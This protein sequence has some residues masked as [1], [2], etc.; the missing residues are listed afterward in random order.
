MKVFRVALCLLLFAPALAGATQTRVDDILQQHA[1]HGIGS[2]A[3][4]TAALEAA[5][6]RPGPGDTVERRSPYWF[7][8]GMYAAHQRNVE[9]TE[10]AVRELRSLANAG[11]EPC[12]TQALLVRGTLAERTRKHTKAQEI[13]EQLQNAPPQDPRT[14]LAY[15]LFRS[16]VLEGSGQFDES[17]AAAV[18]A[19]RMAEEQGMPS[20]QVRAMNLLLLANLGRKD[21]KQA[22]KVSH[23]AL[24]LAKRIG[25]VEQQVFVR[26]NQGFLYSLMEQPK[27][28]LQALLDVVQLT[29]SNPALRQSAMVVQVNLGDFYYLEGDYAKALQHAREGER[30]ARELNDSV[31]IAVAMLNRGSALAALGRHDEAIA[32]IREAIAIGEKADAKQYVANM[33]TALMKILNEAGRHKEAADI[34]PKVIDLNIALVQSER[35]EAVQELQEKY[36]TERKNREIERL[37]LDNARKQAEVNARAWQQRMWATFAV[38]LLLAAVLLMQWLRRVRR[39][40]RSLEVD[41]LVL[42]EQSSQDPLTGAFNR[43]HCQRLMSQHEH[44]LLGKSSARNPQAKVSF[45][46]L[47]VDF[48]KKVNDVYGHGAGDAVLVEVSKRLQTVI[49]EQDALVRWGGEEFVLVLPGTPADGLSVVVDRVLAAIGNAP[50]EADG[51]TIPVTVSAGCVA[52]PAFPG[53]H[54]ED[55]L[56]IA[57][58]AMYLSKSRGRNRGTVLLNIVPGADSDR[59]RRD[60][61]QAEAQGDV[62][63]SSVLGPSVQHLTQADAAH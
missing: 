61:G 2:P 3:Q 50:I 36:S 56:H 30:L 55:A 39:R 10:A 34:A 49:R 53:Q 14:L 52:W 29:Q 20:M 35:E 46:L 40:N 23:E 51:Q 27:Q 24:A 38:M 22:E 21:L 54:W 42:S 17:L 18:Q 12:Q 45:I 8:L 32:L 62:E 5:V 6:D 44:A 4:A 13:L 28:Q 15:H 47:D 9:K 37:S 7:A 48:F 63:L 11:C 25:D 57:D 31:G 33:Y 59:L 26:N 43:R 1:A 58:L 41:N 60:L 16:G 19:S